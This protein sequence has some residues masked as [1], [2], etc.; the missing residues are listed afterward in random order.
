MDDVEVADVGGEAIAE[1]VE[2]VETI[3]PMSISDDGMFVLNDGDD[4][5]SGADLRKGYLQQGDYTQKTQELAQQR[6]QFAAQQYQYQQDMQGYVQRLQAHYAQQAQPQQQQQAG[7]PLEAI[8]KTAEANGGIITTAEAKQLV[9]ALNGRLGQP[10]DQVV[11][12]LQM[13]NNRMDTMQ[14]PLNEFQTERSEREL[15][16]RLDKFFDDN[17]IPAGE[18]RDKWARVLNEWEPDANDLQM[19]KSHEDVWNEMF[20]SLMQS[21]GDLTKQ[22]AAGA[23]AKLSRAG[24]GAAPSKP[25]K[26]P[27]SVE[28]IMAAVD[29]QF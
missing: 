19:G 8:W 15:T 18:A 21:S 7:D 25:L 16:K 13:L 20:M 26:A 3:E 11:Q 4:P 29:P 1:P 2:T 14:Q 6:Q 28:E 12:V 9:E 17:E 23:V 24:G 22:Q 5:M 10:N 27:T